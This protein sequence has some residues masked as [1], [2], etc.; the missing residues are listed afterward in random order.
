M[1][2]PA[3]YRQARQG[4][5]CREEKDDMTWEFLKRQIKGFNEQKH[6]VT[7]CGRGKDEPCGCAQKGLRDQQMTFR[8]SVSRTDV[9]LIPT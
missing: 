8:V 9:R 2:I 3:A 4:A 6:I 5:R 1:T 7:S